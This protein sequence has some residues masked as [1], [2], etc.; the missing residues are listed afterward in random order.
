MQADLQSS[1][2]AISPSR[3]MARRRAP[4]P[5][6]DY[7]ISARAATNAQSS[8]LAWGR[9]CKFFASG[10]VG[11]KRRLNEELDRHSAPLR[12]VEQ[13]ACAFF[14]RWATPY[15]RHVVDSRGFVAAVPGKAEER[16]AFE[17]P[18]GALR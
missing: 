4:P 14:A 2:A 9:L 3:A 12:L 1:A 10:R 16:R 11:R 8:Y 5:G 17:P 7:S 13:K 15:R 18:L 6:V